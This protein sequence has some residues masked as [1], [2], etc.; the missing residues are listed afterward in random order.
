MN[1]LIMAHAC[2]LLRYDTSAFGVALS[3]LHNEVFRFRCNPSA[4]MPTFA[5][6]RST[7]FGLTQTI[8]LLLL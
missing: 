3:I 6:H 8:S 1:F 4:L 2:F 7:L 5:I